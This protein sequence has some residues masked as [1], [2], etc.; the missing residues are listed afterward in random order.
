MQ[1]L[2]VDLH[3]KAAKA[4]FDRSLRETGFAVITNHSISQPEID[5]V[6]ALWQAFF[7]S[8]EKQH[9]LYDPHAQDGYF[10]LGAETA[11]GNDV[12]DLKLFYHVYVN[13]RIPESL[14]GPTLALRQKLFALGQTLLSWLQDCYPES[15]ADDM[16]HM[17]SDSRTLYRIIYYPAL[18]GA[19]EA[20]A[21]RAAE[22]EDIN[23]ITLI[24]MASADGLQVKDL[25]GKWHD[26]PCDPGSISINAGDML[27][28]LTKGYYPATPHR[29][30][31][32]QRIAM[33][34]P[35]MSMPLFVHAKADVALKPGFTAD[36]YLN[37]RLKAIG[38]KDN[39]TN[40]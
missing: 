16:T 25:N 12:A 31:N 32:P 11:K 24:P 40:T 29:V 15:L 35:R 37:Q 22:H 36:D 23:L 7:E 2:K 19:E 26:V 27:D 33:S 17:M 20:G 30:I 21:I 39:P 3:A 13:G 6:Y 14:K 4:D 9:Y 38:L 1:V 34:K 5:A 18:T 28:M 8:D 10:P